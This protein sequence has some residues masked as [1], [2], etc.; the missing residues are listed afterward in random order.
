MCFTTW[1]VK[2]DKVW[3]SVKDHA[4]VPKDLEL[5]FFIQKNHYIHHRNGMNVGGYRRAKFDRLFFSFP[6]VFIVDENKKDVDKWFEMIKLT[7]NTIYLYGSIPKRMDIGINKGDVTEWFYDQYDHYQASTGPMKQTDPRRVIWEKLMKLYSTE[8]L[9]IN[10]YSKMSY[11]SFSKWNFMLLQV[12]NVIQ[13]KA[14]IN[15]D[16][17]LYMWYRHQRREYRLKRG[18]MKLGTLKRKLWEINNLQVHINI[19]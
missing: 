10:D 7:E 2:F 18:A 9:F 6:R 15:W 14:S 8:F 3:N 19:A 1:R 12:L 5:W 17:D 13:N 16:S 4:K 11:V